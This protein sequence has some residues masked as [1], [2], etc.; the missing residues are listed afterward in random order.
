MYSP[1]GRAKEMYLQTWKTL[2]CPLLGSNSKW[3]LQPNK[4]AKE[5]T[6]SPGIQFTKDQAM[7]GPHT[8][9]SSVLSIIGCEL[10]WQ[11]ARRASSQEEFGDNRTL[12]IQISFHR[13]WT[14]GV[15]NKMFQKAV[16]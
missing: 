5:E 16:L 3:K 6:G 15:V 9:A 4:G 7:E 8:S 10:L 13:P 2:P 12:D 11:H 1:N 14:K